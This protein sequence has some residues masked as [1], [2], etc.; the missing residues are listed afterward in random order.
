M[1][2]LAV[3]LIFI[4]F[5]LPAATKL[6]VEECRELALRNNHEINISGKLKKSAEFN[7]KT[8]FSRFL[9]RFDLTG[10]YQR[11]GE[12]FNL[13]IPDMPDL[14]V[15]GTLSN[16]TTGQIGEV[17]LSQIQKELGLYNYEF[18]S[19][20]NFLISGSMEIPIFTGGKIYNQY[21]ISKDR[22]AI[23]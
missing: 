17:P 9:P 1:K 14:P 22:T 13:N 8:A 11:V 7:Q 18:G 15:Y 21:K 16:G 3:L 12:K 20:N 5:L 4:T 10:T 19:E 2:K 6:S 23:S